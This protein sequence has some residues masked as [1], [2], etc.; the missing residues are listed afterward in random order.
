MSKY[1]V[2]FAE[3]GEGAQVMG[4]KYGPVFLK[5]FVQELPSQPNIGNI[6]SSD[7][8]KLLESKMAVV[9][10]F[11]PRLAAEVRSV[12]DEYFPVVIGGDHSCAMGTWSG[13]AARARDYGD[14]GLIWIDAHLDSHTPES[15]ESGAPHGMPLATLLGHGDP[16][17]TML[18]DAHPKLKP[19]NVVV[20]GARS[21]ESGEHALL[22]S[23]GVKIMYVNEVIN[24]GFTDCLN[25]AIEIVTKNTIGYGITLDVDVFDP[26]FMPAVGSPEPTGLIPGDAIAGFMQMDRSNLIGFE[27]VEYN[28]ERDTQDIMAAKACKEIL[29]AIIK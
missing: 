10:D 6:I 1:K 11:M 25:E 16:A 29:Q 22:K 21:Y 5:K 9:R 13:I 17:L 26:R 4:C 18:E 19:E 20:I 7:T 12:A 2:V 23:L 8:F 24:R 15:S 3:I 27:L 14:I 28:P